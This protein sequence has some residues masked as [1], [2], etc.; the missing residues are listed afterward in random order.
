MDQIRSLLPR[1]LRLII[2][3]LAFSVDTDLLKTLGAIRNYVRKHEL[4]PLRACKEVES[5]ARHRKAEPEKHNHYFT[6][7]PEVWPDDVE[8]AFFIG[9]MLW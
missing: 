4:P 5:Y 1:E 8:S 7:L 9:S 6:S 3:A 2:Y